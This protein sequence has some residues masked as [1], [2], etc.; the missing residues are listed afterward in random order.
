[1]KKSTWKGFRLDLFGSHRDT[2]VAF[3]WK[4]TIK[5][6]L[7]A[8]QPRIVPLTVIIYRVH[9]INLVEEKNGCRRM[10]TGPP[11]DGKRDFVP[12]VSR[13]VIND[14]RHRSR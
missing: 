5:F 9:E 6:D 12:V 8:C 2:I 3:R 11:I 4:V 1:M 13:L 10:G 14:A 7:F